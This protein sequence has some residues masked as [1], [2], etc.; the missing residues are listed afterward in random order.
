MTM[1]IGGVSIP[2]DEQPDEGELQFT[3]PQRWVG[4]NFINGNGR[5]LQFVYTD[6]REHRLHF[7][8]SQDTKDDVEA[9]YAAQAT[10][11]GPY[12]FIDSEH[13][14][15]DTGVNVMIT[16]FNPVLGAQNRG[17]PWYDCW[18]TLVESAA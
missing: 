5:L 15:F 2:F 13:P 1:S 16:E 9:L 3:A 7:T 4:I 14:P 6:A 17:L 8:M 11:G 18:I 10:G 12:E